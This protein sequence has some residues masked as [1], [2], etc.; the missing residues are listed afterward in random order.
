MKIS[1]RYF[2]P[3]YF[4]LEMRKFRIIITTIVG[5]LKANWWKIN[6]GKGC[7]FNG[8]PIF[9]N[10]PNSSIIIGN[11]C[12]FNSS[13]TSNLIGVFSPCMISVLKR[14]ASI[15]IGNNCGLS[16]TV[17]GAAREITIGNNVKCGA[18]TLIT[19]TDWHDDDPRSGKDSPV[20]I[21]DNVWLGYGVKV[22]KGV[23]IGDNTLI[24]AGSIVTGDVPPNVIAA[25][26]P[27]K[28]IRNI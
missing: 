27:C 21:G 17:I 10:L 23:T 1:K 26:I 8:I 18:N 24:G 12:R 25:G 6:L 20:K 11:K 7:K 5:K 4:Y 2:H 28:V 9:R 19:D 13:R 16:G 14:G 15:Q 3:H 22:L